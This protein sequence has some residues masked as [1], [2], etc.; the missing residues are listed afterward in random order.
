M[1]VVKNVYPQYFEVLFVDDDKR[2][3]SVVEEYLARQDYLVTVVDSGLKALEMIKE[4]QF[5]VVFADLRMPKLGGLELLTAI[6][7]INPD[8]EVII[9]TGHATVESAIEAMKLGSYDYLQKPFKLERLKILI[10]RIIEKK[11]LQKENILLKSRLKE[12]YRYD[13]LIGVSPEMQEIYEVIDR[14]SGNSPTVL[15]QGESGTGKEILAK[16]IHRN[17]DRSNKPFISINCGAIVDG[18]LESELFGH[19]KGA[20]TGAYKDKVGLF[21]AAEGG[22][23]FLD[24]I[25]EI[26]PFL[27]VKMLRALQ[28][29]KIRPVGDIKEL[30]VDVRVIAATNRDIKKAVE[31]GALRKDLFYRLNV[32]SIKMPVLNGRQGDIPLLVKYFMDKFNKKGQRSVKSV[33]SEAMSALLNYHWPGNVRELENAIERAFALGTDDI[34]K[35]SDLPF[36]IKKSA[37]LSNPDKISYSLKENETVLIKNALSKAGGDKAIAAKMLEIDVSTLYRKI[38]KYMIPDL[39][40]KKPDL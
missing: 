20:F 24:E 32:V 17:S 22:T 15:I 6:R 34:I 10:D 12:R 21:K 29:K 37:D 36:E 38:K 30:D 4:K 26:N 14:I 35:V 9:V 16:V 39:N 11:N 25:A 18:L 28:E 5:D 1:N 3:L 27:Q 8:I 40:I 19:V 33:S 7:D 2:I 31:T 13:E 23:L